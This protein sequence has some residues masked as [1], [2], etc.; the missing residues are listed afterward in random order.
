MSM[1]QVGCSQLHTAVFQ[2]SGTSDREPRYR[3]VL[4]V[5]TPPLDKNASL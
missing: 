5:S 3:E 2:G 4:D 1:Q